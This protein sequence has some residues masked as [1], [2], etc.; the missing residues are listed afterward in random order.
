[1]TGIL[2]A[3]GSAALFRVS[4]PLAKLLLGE[5]SPWL[6]AGLLYLGSGFGLWA[7]RLVRRTGERALRRA[8]LFWVIG[9]VLF[10]GVLGPC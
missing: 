4:A 3:L 1:M 8:N 6:L 2:Y 7:V 10:G 9:A 5:V